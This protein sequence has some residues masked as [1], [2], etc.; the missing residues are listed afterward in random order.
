L[1]PGALKLYD[2]HARKKC[3]RLAHVSFFFSLYT[4]FRVAQPYRGNLHHDVARHR[5]RDAAL[6]LDELGHVVAAQVE[7]LKGIF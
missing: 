4:P 2:P 3:A 1:K 6:A 7:N 5:L